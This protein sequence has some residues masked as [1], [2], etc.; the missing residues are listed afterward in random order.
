MLKKIT[1]SLLAFTA[2]VLVFSFNKSFRSLQPPTNHSG[3]PG[4]GLCSDCHAD[5]GPNTGGGSVVVN[6]L[7]SSFQPGQTYPFSVTIN[8]PTI[9]AKWGFEINARNSNNEP[10]GTFTTTNLNA[11]TISG[12]SEIGHNNAVASD[13]TT[14]TYDNL[15]WTAPSTVAAGDNAVT[16]YVA[17]NAANGNGFNTGD[18]IYS[19]TAQIVLPITLKALDYKIIDDYKVQLDWTTASENNSKA[20]VVEKSEDNQIFHQVGLVKA[21]GNSSTDRKYSFTDAVPTTLNQPVL[22]RLKLVDVNGSA[23]YS[24]TLQVVVKGKAVLV[25]SL[26]PVPARD[27]VEA[28]ITSDKAVSTEAFIVGMDGKIVGRQQI[29]LQK[30][31]NT[32]KFNLPALQ[33]G[34]YLFK[35]QVEGSAQTKTFTVM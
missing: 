19:N 8:H 5:A 6:G 18:F 33:R 15:F 14:F 31:N 30:G 10:T 13:G 9:R 28:K 12:P 20:F 3:A 32:Y 4:G 16:F 17:G 34:V 24:K 35:L 23:K 1:L 26:S 29:S 25:L 22:Y 21:I 11:G 7:P 27:F 2:L